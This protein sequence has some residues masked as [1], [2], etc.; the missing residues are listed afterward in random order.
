M[1]VNTTK[2]EKLKSLI[3]CPKCK[4]A[5]QFTDSESLVCPKCGLIGE[6]KGGQFKLTGDSKDWL[7][8]KFSSD[9]WFSSLKESVRRALPQ[10]YSLIVA[11][12]SPVLSTNYIKRY[13]DSVD[14]ASE[15]VVNLGSG[16]SSLSPAI[17]NVDIY[18]YPAVDLI[19]DIQQLPFADSSVDVVIC[20]AVIE[21]V[22]DP[23][24][25]VAEAYRVL[26]PGGRVLF[27]A[28]FI[29]GIHGVPDDYQRY[30]P[31]GL[32]VLF[33]RFVECKIDIG[34][35]PTSG[36]LWIFH[37]WLAMLLS[38]GSQSLYRLLYLLLL[39][40]LAPV[41]LIDLW[42]V[43]HP[44]AHKIAFGFFISGRKSESPV[45][46]LDRLEASDNLSN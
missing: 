9:Q 18:P 20:D 8:S 12:F 26:K 11:V 24:A 13:L 36:M 37:E 27:Y 32:E 25:V 44:A 21:H 14:C 23:S 17:L 16:C 22:R 40:V 30:T 31:H 38:F 7:C 4:D 43:R 2:A 33:G 45:R 3:R 5:P 41:K 35:G 15:I 10:L 1:G 46:D 42:L 6:C 34:G 28:P 39:V 29:C 19:A